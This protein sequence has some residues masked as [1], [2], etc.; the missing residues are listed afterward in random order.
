MQTRKN[1]KNDETSY[2]KMLKL[3]RD[4]SRAVTLLELVK[5]REKTKREHLHLT[6]E[7]YEKRFG[8]LANFSLEKKKQISVSF[9]SLAKKKFTRINRYQAQ[10]FSGQVLA[11]VSALKASRPAFTQ[12]F[13]NQFGVHQNWANKVSGKVSLPSFKRFNYLN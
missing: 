12:L 9:K 3:R 8:H 6:I 5:R 2:E 4:L 1:R 13:T 11:E 7:V 10:D